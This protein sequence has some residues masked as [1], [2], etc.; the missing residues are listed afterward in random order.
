M[1]TAYEYNLQTPNYETL[2]YII[3]AANLK[4][5]HDRS[6]P[7][8]FHWKIL[9]CR[10]II[11]SN[12][13]ILACPDKSDVKRVH[14]IFNKIGDDFD[15]LNSLFLKFSLV[16]E[17][18]IRQVTSEKFQASLHYT[19]TAKLAPHWNV[20]GHEYLINNRNFLTSNEPQDGVK[21][22]VFIKDQVISINLKPV[23]IHIMRSDEDFRPGECIRVLPSLFKATVSDVYESLPESGNFRTYKDLRRHWKNIHGY[24]LPEEEGLYCTIQFWRGEPLLYPKICV[25]RHFPIITPIPK[26]EENAVLA[27]F[28]S[29]LNSKMSSMLGMPLSIVQPSYDDVRKQFN[30]RF[31]DTQAVSLCTP[32]QHVGSSR[33]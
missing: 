3:A 21:F 26:T 9:K 24:R 2:G 19:I 5:K 27:K 14:I 11:F 10:M 4:D 29:C 1:Q 12:S 25:V 30:E 16:Q 15:K 23:K 13:S 20:L 7:S 28:L 22:N 31:D 17:G 6:A 33:L 18:A 8:H 32:T